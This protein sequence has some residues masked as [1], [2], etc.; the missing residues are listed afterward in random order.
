MRKNLQ[1]LM[2]CVMLMGCHTTRQ[3]T[4]HHSRQP[5][6][7]ND[8]YLDG[9]SESNTR[10]NAVSRH[11]PPPEKKYLGPEYADNSRTCDPKTL[12]ND[13]L[14]GNNTLAVNGLKEKYATLLNESPANITNYSLYHFIEEWYG[15]DYQR[16]GCDKDGIDCSGFVQKLYGE[17]Y[18]IDLL[19]TSLEQF[20][21]CEHLHTA[22]EASEGDLIFFKIHSRHI[23]HVGVYLG[24]NYFVHASSSQG[25]MI[26]N[27]NEE[28]WKKYF[29][30]A[31]HI[32]HS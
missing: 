20:K 10:S 26:S 31:G 18:G 19:R 27:L 29:A 25:V 1:L 15:T 3:T 4:V 30:G 24:N 32:Q 2:G 11:Q 21:N 23:T 5:H 7:I 17:V 8:V 16:G 13:P 6:F 12:N 14:L 22:A 28:Y 9:H